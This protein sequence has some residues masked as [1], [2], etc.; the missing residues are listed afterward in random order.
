M[1]YENGYSKLKMNKYDKYETR[2]I[3]Q[4]WRSKQKELLKNDSLKHKNMLPDGNINIIMHKEY[5]DE[6]Y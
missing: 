3:K 4:G 1:T 6:T 2:R 5:R